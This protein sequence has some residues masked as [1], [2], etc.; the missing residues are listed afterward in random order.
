MHRLQINGLQLPTVTVC[1]ASTTLLKTWIS[2]P[3]IRGRK[4]S[5]TVPIPHKLPMSP[6]NLYTSCCVPRVATSQV[7]GGRE[8]HAGKETSIK[9]GE[10]RILGECEFMKVEASFRKKGTVNHNK[11]D[12]WSSEMRKER[13][14]LN[15][16]IW[17]SLIISVKGSG[18]G[19]WVTMSQYSEEKVE[20]CGGGGNR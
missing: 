15:V 7:W 20:E 12:R 3:S 4:H 6:S 5:L 10:K 11:N 2:M 17:W 18:L 16:G 13:G 8:T 1:L 14:L 9:K 19:R